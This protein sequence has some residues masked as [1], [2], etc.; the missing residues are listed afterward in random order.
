MFVSSTNKR[1]TSKTI[2]V[3]ILSRLHL[4]QIRFETSVIATASNIYRF[5]HVMLDLLFMFLVSYADLVLSVE[6]YCAMNPTQA[7]NKKNMCITL[8]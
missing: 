7:L 8:Q 3:I 2:I 5:C 6:F 1:S 4:M